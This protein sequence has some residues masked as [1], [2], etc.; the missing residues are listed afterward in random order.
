MGIDI[1]NLAPASGAGAGG[2]CGPSSPASNPADVS[3]ERLVELASDGPAGAESGPSP[4]AAARPPGPPDSEQGT[5]PNLAA[6]LTTTAIAAMPWQTT[7]VEAKASRESDS[8]KLPSRD[9]DR[10]TDGTP[11]SRGSESPWAAMLAA[12]TAAANA[13]PPPPQPAQEAAADG[14][15]A[16]SEVSLDQSAPGRTNERS[17]PSAQPPQTG[18]RTAVP[19]LDATAEAAEADP[20]AGGW[21]EGAA[22]NIRAGE[23]RPMPVATDTGA[24]PMEPSDGPQPAERTARTPPGRADLAAGALWNT[25]GAAAADQGPVDPRQGALR[26]TAAAASADQG[27]VDP[28]QGALRNTAGAAAADQGLVDLTRGTPRNTPGV[29]T[30]DQGRTEG[31]LEDASRQ[32]IRA[33]LERG[34]TTDN[35]RPS[36]SGERPDAASSA[37][38]R[39]KA[40]AAVASSAPGPADL[41]QVP[42]EQAVRRYAELLAAQAPT[43]R[44]VKLVDSP[45]PRGGKNTAAGDFAGAFS[46]SALAADPAA[47]G[48]SAPASVD[49]APA[50][51]PVEADPTP[52]IV[53]AVSLLWRDGVGEAKLRLEPEH[54]GSVTVSLRVERGVVTARMT[55]DVPAVR[56][57][58][59]THESE[60]RNSLAGQGL[61]LDQI[62]V[63]AD[64]DDRNRQPPPESNG[65]PRT[66]RT[67]RGGP[68]FQLNA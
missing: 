64:P 41:F 30:T 49:L 38:N 31:Q 44:D 14:S 22:R 29:A 55:A 40:D 23:A 17:R 20:K 51:T 63:S 8:A 60:L 11:S 16:T 5:A 59:R 24:D 27:P 42:A 52:Q 35:A 67:P 9:E 13:A 68:Q 10:G 45:A 12:A 48:S 56:D 34:L 50:A 21:L 18:D 33:M 65:Q 19:V 4:G 28:G 2:F 7:P 46:F 26:N 36:E 66:P 57:W 47:V 62:V 6:Q 39:A 54:L 61:E 37:G 53:K 1:T 58:I 32:A 43:Q 15:G 25:A 3:F